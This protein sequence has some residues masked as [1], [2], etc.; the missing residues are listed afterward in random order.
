MPPVLAYE[1]L[2][3]KT[4]AMF[5]EG[6]SLAQVMVLRLDEVDICKGAG[7]VDANTKCVWTFDGCRIS[8]TITACGGLIATCSRE[9]DPCSDPTARSL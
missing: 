7:R 8:M 6:L 5:R 3:P 9:Y 1:V 4:I 2:S